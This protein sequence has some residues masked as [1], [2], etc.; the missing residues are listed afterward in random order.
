[1]CCENCS[2]EKEIFDYIK[3]I[4]PCDGFVHKCSCDAGC[5]HYTYKIINMLSK[6]HFCRGD[7]MNMHAMKWIAR[8][9][10]NTYGCGDGKNTE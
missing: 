4:K 3:T 8:V 10:C 6:R 1:M 2:S 9:G 7:R 5:V